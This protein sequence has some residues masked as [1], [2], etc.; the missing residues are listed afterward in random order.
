MDGVSKAAIKIDLQKA[1]DMVEWESLWLVMETM[2]FPW[3][4]IFLVQRSVM[5]PRFSININGTLKGCFTS[6]RGLREGDPISSYL[7]LLVLEVFNGIMKEACQGGDFQFHHQCDRQHIIHLIFANDMVIVVTPTEKTV[8]VVMECLFKFGNI[9]CLKL[10]FS[11]RR[12]FFGSMKAEEKEKICRWLSM[13]EG[14]LP[15]KSN[16][17]AFD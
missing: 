11:K 8:K 9:T 4:F 14:S 10:N 12:V 2:G 1:Y 17:R 3:R 13:E 16:F 5:T 7:F 6:S 15:M